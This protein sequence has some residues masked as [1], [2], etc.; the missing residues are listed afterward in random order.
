MSGTSF[1]G[2]L[3]ASEVNTTEIDGSAPGPVGIF[4]AFLSAAASG[5]ILRPMLLIGVLG[6]SDLFFVAPDQGDFIVAPDNG[7]F[8]VSPGRG[9]N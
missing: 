1:Y 3:G 7:P 4:P 8:L 9:L 6:L 2:E 5:G